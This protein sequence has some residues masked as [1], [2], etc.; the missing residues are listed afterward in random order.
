[1]AILVAGRLQIRDGRK[2]VSIQCLPEP[3]DV[4]LVIGSIGPSNHC[5]RSRSKVLRVRCLWVVLEGFMMWNV[6]GLLVAIGTGMC[7]GWMVEPTFKP[8]PGHVLGV[9]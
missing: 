5:H 1:M 3:V 8:A 4:V 7:L 9:E 6:V 2:V